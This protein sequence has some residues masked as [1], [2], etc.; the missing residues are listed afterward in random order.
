MNGREWTPTEYKQLVEM[1]N[2]LVKNGNHS[3]EP[4]ATEFNTTNQ[5]AF[6]AYR[7]AVGAK[8]GSVKGKTE[9]QEPEPKERPESKSYEQGEDFINVICSSKRMLT[10][11]DI[12]NEFKID[13]EVWEV[14]RFKVKTSEGYRKD[15]KVQ[16]EVTNGKVTSGSVDDSGKM[17]VVPLYHLEVRFKKRIKDDSIDLIGALIEDAKKYSPRY[18]KINYPIYNDGYLY[19]IAMYDIHFGRLTWDEESGESYDIKIAEKAIKSSLIKLLSLVENQ[20]ISKILFPM[21]NDFFNVDSKFNTTTGGT[22]QQEDTRWQKTFQ[23]GRELCVWMLDLC[24]QIAPVDV[25]IIP[26]NHDQQRAFYLGDS[27]YSWYH[28]SQDVNINN[29]AIGTKYYNYG[30]TLLGFTHGNDVKLEKLPFIMAYDQPELWA[31][32]KFREW[33]TGDKHHKKGLTPIEDESSGMLIRIIRS[34]VA[35]DAWTYNSGYRSLRASESF[36]WHPENGLTA[37]YTALPDMEN[38]DE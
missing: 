9:Y 13:L 25:L 26:G 5:K 7:R 32:T 2:E 3:W 21:G 27:L 33:H 8:H 18:P 23:K 14:D 22:P 37:Q 24:S 15:R 34:L 31:K 11:D 20:K 29:E 17:L 35:F 28:N 1:R 6:A 10:K 16:W 38:N 36:L 30:K 4:I 19:E 12:I